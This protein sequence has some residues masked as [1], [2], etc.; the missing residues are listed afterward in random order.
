MLCASEMSVGAEVTVR[1]KNSNEKWR[2]RLWSLMDRLLIPSGFTSTVLDCNCQSILKTNVNM[3]M[4][5]QRGCQRRNEWMSLGMLRTAL[6]GAIKSTTK[7][8]SKSY[9]PN[10]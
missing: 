4:P 2:R 8:S 6:S 9:L 1:V 10:P 7:S 3:H 5:L